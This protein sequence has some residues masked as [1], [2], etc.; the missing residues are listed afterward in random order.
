ME[1]YADRFPHQLAGGQQQRVALARALVRDPNLL[2]LDEPFSAVD[3]CLRQ[4]LRDELM[5]LFADVGRPVLIVTHDLEEARR[6]AD[7]VGVVIE[8]RVHR[9][10]PTDEV[11][12]S[13]GDV[14]SARVLGWRNL[15]PVRVASGTRVGGEWGHLDLDQEP[16]VD[17][18]HV[19]I[20]AEHLRFRRAATCSGALL[21]DL[22]QIVDLGAYREL[23][24]RLSDGTPLFIHRPSDEPLP[25]VGSR[26]FIDAPAAHLKALVDTPIRQSATPA[27]TST[28]HSVTGGRVFAA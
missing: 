17:V 16:G 5:G 19:G 13:P 7:T 14:A 1:A 20:R 18:S 28:T 8:G 6:T 26:L 25:T 15:L 12:R 3:T 10:G 4:R 2:L 27:R 22:V 11:L 24:C 23:C 9:L 21:A